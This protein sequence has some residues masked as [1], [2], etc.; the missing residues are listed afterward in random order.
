MLSIKK[1]S[2]LEGVG[3]GN[4]ILWLLVLCSAFAITIFIERLHF[5]YRS[6]NRGNQ[7]LLGVKKF[8]KEGSI[9]EALKVCEETEGSVSNIVKSG[10]LKHDRGRDR[11]EKA[12]EAQGQ[13][14]MARLEK[15]AKN[16]A[17]VAHLS[18]LIGLL[19][20]VLG[21]IDAFSKMRLTPLMEVSTTQIGESM[22]YALVTTAA[23][24]VVAIPSLM[25]YHYLQSRIESL[26]LEMQTTA[27]QVVDLL[28]QPD[29]SYG[30]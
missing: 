24:L 6:E 2:L 1:I 17:L 14:E 7:F 25:G 10:L 30:Y 29:D 20:T 21:L 4:V 18:P 13:E 12:M 11:I 3:H 26:A 23:G 8:I 5:L 27:N 9:L 15:N 22:Q 16:L 19:G 28:I